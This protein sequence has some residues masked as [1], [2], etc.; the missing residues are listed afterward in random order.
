MTEI[1]KEFIEKLNS[2]SKYCK[3]R[4]KVNVWFV[5]ILGKRCSYIA[6]EKTSLFY[7][8]ICIKL[9]DKLGIVMEVNEK[10]FMGKREQILKE[11]REIIFQK[12][13]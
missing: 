2:F 6:G 1:S 4:Y 10:I 12:N 9:T 3:E 13:G 5:E 7:P 11:I 8:P